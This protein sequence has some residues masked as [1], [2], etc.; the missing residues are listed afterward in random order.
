MARKLRPASA[1]RAQPGPAPGEVVPEQSFFGP[2]VL[3]ALGCLATLGATFGALNLAAIHLSWERWPYFNH[4]V[5]GLFQLYGFVLLF[6]F[7][8]G[9]HMV[10]RFAGVPLRAVPA[11]K[12]T[13]PLVL[14][15]LAARA[16][17]LWSTESAWSGGAQ[18]AGGLLLLAA[19]AAGAASFAL[20]LLTGPGAEAPLPFGRWLLGGSAWFVVSGGLLAMAGLAHA[21]GGDFRHAALWHEPAYAAAL[22]GG[23][24]SWIV[25]MLYRFGPAFLKVDTHHPS[26]GRSL[27]WALQLSVAVLVASLAVRDHSEGAL[28]QAGRLGASLAQALFGAAVT[29]YAVRAGVFSRR[30]ER[31][32]E[33]EELRFQV[34]LAFGF[35]V[36]HFLL[37][38]LHLWLDAR[39]ASNHILLDGVRHAFAQ[40]FV[41]LFVLAVACRLVPVLVNRPLPLAPAAPWALLAM[42]VGA[43]LRLLEVVA[44]L[45]HPALLAA[46]GTSGALTAVG[47]LVVSVQLAAATL[48]ARPG[49]VATVRVPL[50][51]DQRVADL[52]ASY[53]D[54]LGIL[55]GLGFLPLANPVS[56]AALAR[57]VTLEQACSMLGKDVE[58]V[59]A[60][61]RQGLSAAHEARREREPEPPGAGRG[62]PP[63]PR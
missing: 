39:S 46:S 9:F 50:L 23:T 53:P 29:L 5:H 20:T 56:R 31:R 62:S 41:A 63:G 47:A 6:V 45:G 19:T 26:V 35:V 42:A 21:G 60:A 3:T 54:A 37:A 61:L 22:Y 36:V 30:P 8:I 12:S 44:A 28:S 14:A 10:P 32:A 34:R 27:F 49:S 58:E 57:L 13:L 48:G 43:G 40:G 15:G 51:P 18:A 2:F 59:M 38:L 11:A 33:D 7:G 24:T 17:G 1:R 52:L 55:V 25:G 16:A 4:P